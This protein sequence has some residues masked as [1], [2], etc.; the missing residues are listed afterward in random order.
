MK[1]IEFKFNRKKKNAGIKAM[2]IVEHPA[3]EVNF[4]KLAKEEKEIMLAVDKKQHIITGPALI[5][6]KK[7]YR[8]AKSLEDSEDGYIFFSADTIKKLAEAYMETEQ[9]NEIT[10]GHEGKTK[11]LKT[12]ES[13]IVLDAEKDKAKVLGFDVPAGT[14]M[15]SH[16]VNNDDIWNKIE[17]GELNGYSIEASDLDKL[18]L[19][20]DIKT[21][22]IVD[23]K[24][25][26]PILL[27]DKTEMFIKGSKA[28]TKEGIAFP[29]G[30]YE[31]VARINEYNSTIVI[32][33]GIQIETQDINVNKIGMSNE[34][35]ELSEEDVAKII[36]VKLL[37]LAKPEPGETE[38]EFI[39]RCIKVVIKDGTATD[40]KQG[41]AICKS[42]WDNK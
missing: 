36:V 26:W 31:T 19:S 7:I 42:M 38:E 35:Q 27:K 33:D 8:S 18:E 40:E 16:K 21:E 13:W 2:S 39:P 5:P 41:F 32:K 28:Y 30:S 6:N 15:L 14:W 20:E 24:D 3:M 12:I 34:E 17:N 37:K 23:V 29:D 11:D 9:M 4:I 25:L 22:D 1:L 10:L